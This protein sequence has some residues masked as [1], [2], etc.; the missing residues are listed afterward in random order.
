MR[1][2]TDTEL[3][4]RIISEAREECRKYSWAA[5]RDQWLELY[6]GLSVCGCA[7]AQCG[8]ALPHREAIE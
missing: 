7:A 1:L 3:A 5:V 2:L 4:Q 6:E 8:E